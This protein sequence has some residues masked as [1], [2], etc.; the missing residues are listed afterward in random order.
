MP[1]EYVSLI[2]SVLKIGGA[3]FLERGLVN[4]NSLE[5]II[6]GAVALAGVVWGYYHRKAPCPV[7]STITTP[8]TPI[9]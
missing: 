8:I 7:V 5:A 6:S 1:D 3:M 4:S 2:R 9:K